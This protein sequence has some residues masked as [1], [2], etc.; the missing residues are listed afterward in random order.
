MQVWGIALH[1]INQAKL[2]TA[3]VKMCAVVLYDVSWCLY[4]FIW[5]LIWCYCMLLYVIVFP[6]ARGPPAAPKLLK[7]WPL[8]TINSHSSAI[9]GLPR[10]FVQ[11]RQFCNA[12]SC[13]KLEQ[14]VRYIC[15]V[16]VYLHVQLHIDLELCKHLHTHIIYMCARMR[17]S[18]T[19]TYKH[20]LIYVI[21]N[22]F[23]TCT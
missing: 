6:C 5:I 3:L 10:S 12:L 17:Y 8:S 13:R 1:Y 23:S 19:Q 18:V 22:L 20:V 14:H 11:W 9:R 4:M 2:Y 21:I 15:H 7:C 16:W